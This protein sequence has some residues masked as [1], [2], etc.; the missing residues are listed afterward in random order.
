MYSTMRQRR[1]SYPCRQ[2]CH[3][4]AQLVDLSTQDQ[5]EGKRPANLPQF[6]SY[7]EI[8]NNIAQSDNVSLPLLRV[9]ILVVLVVSAVIASALSKTS[10]HVL[11]IIGIFSLVLYLVWTYDSSVERRQRIF[12]ETVLDSYANTSLLEE[13]VQERTREMLEANKLLKDVNRKLAAASAAQLQT[14]A[15]ISHEIRT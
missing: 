2:P 14:F 4:N 8:T 6:E 3:E 5:E 13:L 15:C 12:M 10:I 9:V 1:T 7:D 11:N